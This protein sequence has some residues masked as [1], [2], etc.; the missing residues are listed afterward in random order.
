VTRVRSKPVVPIVPLV[1]LV[2]ILP[3]VLVGLIGSI[4]QPA[5]GADA[6]P[7]AIVGAT[8]HT[9]VGPPIEGGTIVVRG[10]TIAEV[11]R[12]L[13]V[14]EGTRVID[15]TGLVVAP[16]FFD[17]M[18]T[19]GLAEIASLQATQDATELGTWNPHLLAITAVH[20]ASEHVPVARANGVTHAGAAPAGASYGIAGRASAIHLDG[21]TV[22]E[23]ALARELGVVVTWPDLVTRRFDRAT[24]RFADRPF[25]EAKKE[26]DERV[27]EIRGWLEAARRYATAQHAA[28]EDR[29]P[30]DARL[31]GLVPVVERELPLLVRAS[32]ERQIRDVLALAEEES[33]RVVL[34]GGQEAWRLASR[35]AERG[36][37]VI[38]GP[39]Q[40]LPT[41]EDDPY[42]RSYTLARALREAGVAVAIS[43]FGASASF[44]LPYEAA[45]AVAF[46]LSWEDGL[47]AIT[48][49]PAEIFGLDDRLGTIEPGK[50]ANLVVTD[51]DPL[52]IRTQIRHVLVRGA[53]V[54]LETKHTRS[55]QR[56]RS[57]PL[58]AKSR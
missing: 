43:T 11:G 21:W 39:T 27:G 14:P 37:A 5:A 23:M 2:P 12:D 24:A 1:P 51:G 28:E 22:E 20:P 42:D 19:L 25:T 52:E 31:Q 34:V 35:L 13:P 58:P 3:L 18:S 53:V 46:G 7:V 36:V 29:P 9:L 49:W 10:E 40:S 38:L 6:E 55:Y 26:Y 15:A 45:Q 50:L 4:T 30:A 56:Y 47:R 54:D 17:A 41:R 33:L 48:Q 8:V 57:R 16:G 44:T 32:T